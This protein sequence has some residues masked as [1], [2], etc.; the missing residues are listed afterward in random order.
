MGLSERLKAVATCPPKLGGWEPLGNFPL[1]AIDERAPEVLAK[2]LPQGSLCQRN[3]SGQTSYYVQNQRSDFVNLLFMPPRDNDQQPLS[4]DELSVATQLVTARRHPSADETRQLA[5]LEKSPPPVV[6]GKSAGIDWIVVEAALTPALVTLVRLEMHDHDNALFRHARKGDAYYVTADV[7]TLSRIITIIQ[8]VDRD[9][10]VIGQN[11]A[12]ASTKDLAMQLALIQIN[13]RNVQSFLKKPFRELAP[14]VI[15]GAV[16]VVAA[17]WGFAEGME[18]VQ[19]RKVLFT[20]IVEW[21]RNNRRP[22]SSGAG[23]VSGNN[24]ASGSDR[25]PEN[26]KFS[27]LD[28]REDAGEAADFQIDSER[29]YEPLHHIHVNGAAV[30]AGVVMGAVLLVLPEIAPALVESSPEIVSWTAGMMTL[31]H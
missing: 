10:S 31:S 19:H 1:A 2:D 28:D 6:D 11:K 23:G 22:P 24:D 8:E 5:A 13:Q 12:A 16:S 25:A 14:M 21:I 27:S 4:E 30:A 7:E 18:L 17:G 15:I 9:L 29:A 26:L 20:K 3:D